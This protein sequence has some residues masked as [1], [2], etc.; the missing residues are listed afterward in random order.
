MKEEKILTEA[1]PEEVRAAKEELAEDV[2]VHEF[3]EAFEWEGKVYAK[4]TFD[5]GKL[6]GDD[7][8]AVEDELSRTRHVAVV[9]Q[10]DMEFKRRIAVRAV[11]APLGEDAF[12]AM[13]AKD[14]LVIMGRVQGFFIS[15]D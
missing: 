8:L 1:T 12:R 7:I 4:L 3:R 6:T 9:P 5:F 10:L 15:L 11:D 2:Y 14:F 13:K